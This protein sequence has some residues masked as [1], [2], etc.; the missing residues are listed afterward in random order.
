MS[1]DINPTALGLII[2]GI[3]APLTFAAVTLVGAAI[4]PGYSHVRNAV[5]ELVETGA[6]HR[7][8]LNWAFLFYNLF[9]IAFGLGL[10]VLSVNRTVMAAGWL[11]VITGLLGAIMWPFPMDHIG[12]PATPRGRGHLVLA[13][14]VSLATMAAI[15]TFAI[16]SSRIPGWE[17]FATYSYVSFGVVAVTG[18]LAAFSAVRL[19][20]TMGLLE[21]L[22]IGAFL[23]WQLVLAIVLLVRDI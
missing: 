7:T 9:T 17:S 19:W 22:T 15:L 12:T 2:A 5:S 16:G 23:Q 1:I 20:R 10:T 21:R 18:A 6:P 14:L 4:R 3:L 13:G 11:V 8:G